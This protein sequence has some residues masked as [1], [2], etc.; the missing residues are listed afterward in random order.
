ML[1]ISSDY[2]VY[3]SGFL[4]ISS[5]FIDVTFILKHDKG[6][7]FLRQLITR[8]EKCLLQAELTF[9]WNLCVHN[10]YVPIC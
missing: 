5:K 2:N 7:D 6:F 3:P 1:E 9:L 4:S 10:V 8:F